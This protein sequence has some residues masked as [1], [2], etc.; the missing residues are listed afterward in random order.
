MIFIK[1]IIK[2]NKHSFGINKSIININNTGNDNIFYNV[3]NNDDTNRCDEGNIH[4][5]VNEEHIDI[6]QD[7]EIDSNSIIEIE[8]IYI[9]KSTVLYQILIILK[10]DPLII[11]FFIVILL[12]GFGS[13]VIDSFLFIRL[14]Q[15]GGDIKSFYL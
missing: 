5:E 1:L 2:L 15:L 11:L 10:S 4:I 3:V 8:N 6:L 13:G 14:K 12:S 9:E 7:I